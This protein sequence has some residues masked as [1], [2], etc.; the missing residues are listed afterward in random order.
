[1]ASRDQLFGICS[2]LSGASRLQKHIP[3][4]SVA[5]GTNIGPRWR[6]VGPTASCV[7]DHLV[8]CVAPCSGHATP[9]SRILGIAAE[10]WHLVQAGQSWRNG[11]R[12]P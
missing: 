10:K 9:P 2:D 8:A 6:R 7:Q 11:H 3:A 4:I 5:K 12:G 1:M